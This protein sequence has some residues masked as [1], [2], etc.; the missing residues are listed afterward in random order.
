M[1]PLEVQ[2]ERLNPYLTEVG[3]F[4]LRSQGSV[5]ST[6]QFSGGLW[7]SVGDSFLRSGSFLVFFD[8]RVYQAWL[9]RMCHGIVVSDGVVLVSPVWRIPGVLFWISC[10]VLILS[11]DTF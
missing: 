7:V 6:F 9:F 4:R 3:E 1:F 11:W 5:L 10:S 8:G 2:M